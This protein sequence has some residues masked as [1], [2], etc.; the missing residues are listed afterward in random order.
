MR[1]IEAVESD[2]GCESCGRRGRPL[3]GI[4]LLDGSEPFEVCVPCAGVAVDSSCRLRLVEV[5]P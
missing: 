1:L 4:D 2:R 5:E 3:V